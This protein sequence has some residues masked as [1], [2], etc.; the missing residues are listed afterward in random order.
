MKV[1]LED[2]RPDAESSF[3]LLTPKI[4]GR[5]YWHY[6]PEFELL[7]IEGANGSRHIGEHISRYEGSDLAFIGPYIPHLNFD[8]GVQTDYEKVVVQLREDFLGKGFLAAPELTDI[9]QL[10]ERAKRGLVF[11]GETKRQAG[12]WIKSLPT[13]P[14]FRQLMLL[15]EIFQLLASSEEVET[16]EARPLENSTALKEQQRMKQIEHFVA[17]HFQRVINMEELAQLA[18]LSPAAFCRFF[19]RMSRMTFTEY[20]NR[21]RIQQSKLLLMQGKSVTDTCFQS[22]FENLSYFNKTFKKLAGE[23]PTSF[24]QR[25][26]G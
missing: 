21:Y 19:K 20:L 22:G 4:S 25:V 12:E 1:K 3:R 5:F 9:R 17:L 24:K 18:N 2:V 16:L 15:M 26:L 14:R 10:F 23:N 7:Y 13:Q 11:Y 8:Y 6:H